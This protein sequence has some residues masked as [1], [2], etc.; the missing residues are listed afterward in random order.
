MGPRASH[1]FSG[2]AVSD[3]VG[4]ILVFSIVLTGVGLVSVNGFNA[5]S[6]YTDQQQVRNAERGMQAVSSTL[7]E[8]HRNGDTYRQFDISLGG[9]NVRYNRTVISLKSSDVDLSGLPE[10]ADPDRTDIQVNALEQQFDRSGAEVTLSYEAGGLF[11]SPGAPASY[12][13]TLQCEPGSG[14]TT[15]VSL[16]NLTTDDIF[17]AGEYDRDPTIQARSA[18]EDL[19]VAAENEFASFEA[20]LDGQHRVF[21][22]GPSPKNITIDVSDSGSPDQ[23]GTYLTENDWADQG[24]GEYS[25]EGQTVLIRISTIELSLLRAQNLDE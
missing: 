9:G 20:E 4:F 22:A 10:S 3:V 1:P 6:E 16:V 18:P 23:W 7:D 12:E 21:E 19:P 25:C 8:L 14:G 15:I 17:T 24:G 5:L 11:R 2:R 13:P